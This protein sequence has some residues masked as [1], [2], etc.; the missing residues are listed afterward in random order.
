MRKVSRFH[1]LIE[2]LF[3]KTKFLKSWK[4]IKTPN[5]E[6]SKWMY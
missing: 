6:I 5:P 3:L 2:P 4:K 1:F